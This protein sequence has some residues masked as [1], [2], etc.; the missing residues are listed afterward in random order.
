MGSWSRGDIYHYS[1]IYYVEFPIA[2][3]ATVSPPPRTSLQKGLPSIKE[4]TSIESDMWLK[5]SIRIGLGETKARSAV[6]WTGSGEVDEPQHL[7]QY[8]QLEAVEWEIVQEGRGGQDDQEVFNGPSVTGPGAITAQK[9]TLVIR[10]FASG[11]F[12]IIGSQMVV[13]DVQGT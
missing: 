11:F 10:Q 12:D 9:S 8:D 3:R 2:L 1:N 6:Y 4:H 7:E 5:G 13:P